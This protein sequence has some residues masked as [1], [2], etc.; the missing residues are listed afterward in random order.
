MKRAAAGRSTPLGRVASPMAMHHR[1]DEQDIAVIVW[2]G[3]VGVGANDVLQAGAAALLALAATAGTAEAPITPRRTELAANAAFR[4]R[5]DR[6]AN[7]PCGP[8]GA[9]RGTVVAETGVAV[10]ADRVSVP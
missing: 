8:D 1:G 2:S 7:L 3:L 4:A 9:A 5:T 10:T 6:M